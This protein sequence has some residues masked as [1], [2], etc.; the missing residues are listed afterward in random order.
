MYGT[1]ITSQLGNLT[2]VA[3]PI[4]ANGVY[5]FLFNCMIYSSAN[6]TN[7]I[8]ACLSS[9]PSFADS[10][11]YESTYSIATGANLNITLQR[12]YTNVTNIPFTMYFYARSNTVNTG[13][14]LQAGTMN[15]IKLA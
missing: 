9:N 2:L 14:Y 13:I 15:T 11:T 10:D 4:P 8:Y 6:G 5:L 7:L 1:N 3:A 12:V